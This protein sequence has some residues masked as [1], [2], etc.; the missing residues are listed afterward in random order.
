MTKIHNC[1]LHD[2]DIIRDLMP[3][4]ADH[5]LSESGTAAVEDHLAHCEI[6]RRIYEEMTDE[7]NTG[8]S[9]EEHLAL[10]GFRK[11]QK[12]TR[13]LKLAA[14]TASVLLLLLLCGMI[15][16]LFVIGRPISFP[17]GCSA[18]YDEATNSVTIKGN[19]ENFHIGRVT[20]KRDDEDETIIYLLLY[21]TA[22][23]PF[24]REKNDIS[25][26]ISDAKGCQIYQAL[27]D[28]NRA[29]IYSWANDRYDEVNALEEE[30]YRRVPAL[31]A[32]TDILSYSGGID[33]VDEKEGISFSVDYLL[34]ENASYWYWN[35]TLTTDGELKPADFEVWISFDEPHTVLIYDYRTGKWTKDYSVIEGRRPD[36]VVSSPL[37]DS[38]PLHQLHRKNDS[39][40]LVF[41]CLQRPQN[42][43]GFLRPLSA[44]LTDCSK[45]RV[46]LPD[47]R[48]IIE[49]NDGNILRDADSL[50]PEEIHK[51]RR[52]IIRRC[53]YGGKL[54][55]LLQI[56]PI[57]QAALFFLHRHDHLLRIPF[58]CRCLKSFIAVLVHADA[59]VRNVQDLLMAHVLQIGSRL[60][61][62]VKVVDRDIRKPSLLLKISL[63]HHKRNMHGLPQLLIILPAKA[64][65]YQPFH[66]PHRGKTNDLPAVRR[67][68]DHHKVP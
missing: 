37:P 49:T 51:I 18:V 33:T 31:A 63:I 44:V 27:P 7:L 60:K 26:T 56:F 45:G 58:S 38:L 43:D 55:K 30:I 22:A 23:L 40:S 8:L 48:I 20:W 61:S 67:R 16:F 12:R 32:E 42:A 41:P 9:P 46:C 65:D 50:L 3:G 47:H 54:P 11:I 28:Y 4:Y 21:E 1:N 19:S 29:L 52:I 57:E 10:D 15:L 68:L 2:C 36:K 17:I 39:S 35:D 6:C 64:N 13:T 53:K 24:A 5:M 34:G 14:G 66:I 25:V 59:V 62:A